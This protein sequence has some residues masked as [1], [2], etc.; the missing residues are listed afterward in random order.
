MA[1]FDLF[2]RKRKD[3]NFNN[4]KLSQEAAE[5]ATMVR[6]SQHEIRLLELETIKLKHQ[7]DQLALQQEIQLNSQPQAEPKNQMEELMQMY[8]FFQSLMPQKAEGQSLDNM[9]NF[10]AQI[11][12]EMLH[13]E[14]GG[15]TSSERSYSPQPT[16]SELGQS[17][18]EIREQIK[19]LPPDKIQLAKK[20]PSKIVKNYIKKNTDYDDKTIDRAIQIIKTEM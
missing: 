12:P 3:Y 8:M 7:R 4:S 16:A 20:L 1:F 9:S 19:L 18:D 14:N 17:D 13:G 11:N 10:M 5:K 15:S 6:K 2:K